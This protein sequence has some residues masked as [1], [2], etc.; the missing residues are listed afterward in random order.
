MK[1]NNL[2]YT[3]NAILRKKSKIE[4]ITLSDLQFYLK[5][6]VFKIIWYQH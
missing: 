2:T 1:V 3:A 6:Q 5:S 4:G